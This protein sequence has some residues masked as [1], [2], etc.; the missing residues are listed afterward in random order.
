Q[1][2]RELI[3][4]EMVE[5]KLAWMNTRIYGL[6]SASYL[7]TGLVDRGEADFSLESA[8]TKVQ[9]SD[10]GW[11]ALNRAFQVHGGTAFMADHPLA[12]ALRD[13]RIFPI[14]EGSNDVMRAYVALNGLKALSEDLPDVASLKIT[15]PLKAIGVLAPYVS[16]RISRRVR[17]E[18]LRAAHPTFAGRVNA[19]SEQT[20]RLRDRAEAALRKHGKKVQER[21][22][23]Q[24]RLANAASGIYSQVAVISRASAV[25]ARDGLQIS[26]AEKTVA[27]NFLKST[28]REVNRQLRAL[29]I[30]DDRFVHQIGRAVR[31]TNG[32]AF[33]L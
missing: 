1:F 19:V 20:V 13:F 30:N 9:A 28:E 31:Q 5:E 7:T 27:M 11:Y 16:G 29:E 32:Y 33:D 15:D 2:G 12:K 22:L 26:G 14:F 8:M 10:L 17:P 4:F 24:K 21:Q 23:I 3:D 18:K 25:F 6:E